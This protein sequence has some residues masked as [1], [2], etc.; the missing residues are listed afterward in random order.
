M[1]SIQNRYAGVECP[2]YNRLLTL[3]FASQQYR[4]SILNFRIKKWRLFWASRKLSFVR[5]PSNL[6]LDSYN[7][8]AEVFNSTCITTNKGTKAYQGINIT[9]ES[10]QIF[11]LYSVH[12]VHTYIINT[13]KLPTLYYKEMSDG[14]S[15]WMAR[16][17]LWL[18]V[19][20]FHNK[21]F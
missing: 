11:T 10:R 14:C 12:I 2:L 7:F 6:V 3:T 13:V 5:F 1:F 21:L 15:A 16:Y 9:Q 8:P 19:Y 17:L 4:R 20:S 18:Y